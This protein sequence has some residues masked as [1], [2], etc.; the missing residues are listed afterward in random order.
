VSRN[1]DASGHAP[2]LVDAQV[3]PT[4]YVVH[5]VVPSGYVN[6]TANP[7]GVP[8]VVEGGLYDVVFR[9]AL[10]AP[11]GYGWVRGVV[12]NDANG[13]GVRNIL[14]EVGLAG[15]TVQASNGASMQTLGDGSYF[16]LLPAGS[17]TI[18]QTNLAGWVS[19]TP[20]VVPVSVASGGVHEVDFGDQLCPPGSPICGDPGGFIWLSGYVYQDADGVLNAPD[21]LKGAADVG[22]AAVP[23]TATATVGAW[24]AAGST[25]ASGFYFLQVPAGPGQVTVTLP[26]GYI[27]LT[28]P[29]VSYDASV[30]LHMFRVDFA[31][32]STTA[33]CPS[34]GVVHGHVYSDTN[35]DGVFVLGVDTPTLGEAT[36]GYGGQVQRTNWMYA[37]VCVPAGGGVVTSTNPSG[38]TN[39][40]PNS[41]NVTVPDGGLASANF[42]KAFVSIPI[43]LR[44]A[45][46]PI[47]FRPGP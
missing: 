4:N 29:T 20:D 42:G 23:V 37:F 47:V 34:G 26:A 35:G 9:D 43:A 18:T 46:I 7:V 15:V 45:Y 30:S 33:Q 5:Q 25:D 28:P 6:L 21:G 19:T 22:L 38:Y 14:S 3:T 17:R 16:F 36:V 10:A 2:L 24:T 41:V 27:A 40:T 44:Y 12:F 31:A 1:T 11:F 13:D 32:I 8:G 39:T